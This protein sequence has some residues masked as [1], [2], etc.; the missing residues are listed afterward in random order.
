VS[1]HL[2]APGV[3][4]DERVSEHPCEHASME[5]AEV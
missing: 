4:A 5:P 1:L 3:E 2:D